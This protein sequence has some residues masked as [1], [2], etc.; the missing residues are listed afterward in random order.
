MC[1]TGRGRHVAASPQSARRIV[2]G[3]ALAAVAST[4]LVGVGLGGGSASGV[5]S[6]P[7]T[8][9]A[10][11]VA[12]QA[13]LRT[14][15]V[16]P[17]PVRT[18]SEAAPTRQPERSGPAPTRAAAPQRTAAA[19]EPAADE[20]TAG[21]TVTPSMPVR[22]A[23]QPPLVPGTP[24]TTTAKA[25]VDL[26]GRRAW[27]IQDGVVLRRAQSMA[28]GDEIDPT[29]L[30]TFQVEWK[31]QQWTSREY[32]TQMPFAV[33][34]AE[35]GIAFHEGG[36]DSNSAGCVKLVHDDAVAWFNYL[37]VGDEVQ[38]R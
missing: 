17:G 34:F 25:C 19:P 24:C 23:A 11:Q 30:G 3:A 1:S 2:I 10:P 6:P 31:A 32:L 8:Q 5:E 27:L 36:Q 20:P 4:V 28:V 21:R 18:T 38:I 29:P 33:F 13:A 14:Q 35:G 7:V 15:P 37:Q 16:T 26:A 12:P 22:A 9:V